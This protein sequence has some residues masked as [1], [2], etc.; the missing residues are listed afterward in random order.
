VIHRVITGQRPGQQLHLLSDG[1]ATVAQ[2]GRYLFDKPL[3]PI[4]AGS[5]QPAIVGEPSRW[6]G[7]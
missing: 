4:N 6:H 7:G 1:S 3:F 2:A 5:C